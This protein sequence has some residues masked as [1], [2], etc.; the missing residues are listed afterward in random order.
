MQE[1]APR[2]FEEVLKYD[3]PDTDPDQV[4][5][6]YQMLKTAKI[7]HLRL[8]SFEELLS[9]AERVSSKVSKSIQ[10]AFLRIDKL[11]KALQEK[12]D[13]Y[14][15]FELEQKEDWFTQD[16]LDFEKRGSEIKQSGILSA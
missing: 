3:D 9:N 15:I 1:G 12:I 13:R 7:N 4:E 5:I 2:E 14:N 11:F 6:Y 16:Y 8:S 10:Q